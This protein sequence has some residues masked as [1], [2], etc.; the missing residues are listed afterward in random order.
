MKIGTDVS[1]RECRDSGYMVIEFKKSELIKK[2]I[3]QKDVCV[4]CSQSFPESWTNGRPNIASILENEPIWAVNPDEI[5]HSWNSIMWYFEK[6]EKQIL[7]MCGC[8]SREDYCVNFNN[9]N[10][11]DLLNLISDVAAYCGLE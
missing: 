5:S 4:K 8:A 3:L 6:Y 10:E 1:I 7:S 11:Y 2:G 9:P